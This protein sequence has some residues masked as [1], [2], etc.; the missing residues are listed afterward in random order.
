[1]RASLAFSPSNDRIVS[2]SCSAGLR[3]ILGDKAFRGKRVSH[4]YVLSGMILLF[5]Q[6]PLWTHVI[7][8]SGDVV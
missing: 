2:R 1:M 3:K 4:K 6:K 8:H 5:S 7:Q